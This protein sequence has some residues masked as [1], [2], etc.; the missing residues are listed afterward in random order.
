MS[1][2]SVVERLTNCTMCNST[3]IDPS[4]HLT[5]CRRCGGVLSLE[6]EAANVV[7]NLA[8]L[9]RRLSRFA[10][11][12]PASAALEYLRRHELAGEPM[13]ASAERGTVE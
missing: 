6:Y 5:H 9:V 3:G 11:P 2:A 1:V 10:P 12:G 13:R 7:A 4:P 8:T